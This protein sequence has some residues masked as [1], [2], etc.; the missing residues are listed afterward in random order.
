MTKICFIINEDSL[1][2]LPT[3]LVQSSHAFTLVITESTFLV[4]SS[5]AFTLVITESI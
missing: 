2:S 4:Q 3:F 5:H 1:F